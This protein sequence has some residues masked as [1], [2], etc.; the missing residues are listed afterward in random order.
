MPDVSTKGA[1][2]QTTRVRET[3]HSRPFANRLAV[4]DLVQGIPDGLLD[5][6]AQAMCDMGHCH[7]QDLAIEPNLAM[8]AASEA[9]RSA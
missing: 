7:D 1:N 2:S 3:N 8:S 4:T 9:T 6:V 5:D